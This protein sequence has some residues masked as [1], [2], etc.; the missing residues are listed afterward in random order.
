VNA[1]QDFCAE[2][3]AR[4]SNYAADPSDCTRFIYCEK[5]ATN[6]L[7]HIS[8]GQCDQSKE[9]KYFVNGYCT[10]SNTLCAPGALCSGKVPE[11]QVTL[12]VYFL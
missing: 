12:K 7:I 9:Q 1:A 10:K 2:A 8:Y 5:D 4:N 11:Y 6:N 3:F